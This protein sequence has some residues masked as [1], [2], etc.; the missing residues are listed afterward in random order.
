MTDI[1]DQ[2]ET[3]NGYFWPKGDVFAYP[4]IME[5]L[6]EVPELLR[7]CEQKR[8]CIQAGGNCG[9]WVIPLAGAFERVYTFEPDAKNFRCLVGNVPH[10]NVIF[11]Q[12]ALGDSAAHSFGNLDQWCG[13]RNAGAHRMELTDAGIVPVL[14]VDSLRLDNVDLIQLDIE[15]C[16]MEALRGAENTISASRPVICL[17]LRNHSP[18]F[19]TSDD[20]IRAWLTQRGYRCAKSINFDEFWTP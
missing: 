12:A 9:L 5:E 10:D 20:E 18:H 8:V 16:E 6:K 1:A 13:A 2:I 3:R 15:G 11:M 17:E 14:S 4:T 7:L 19:G